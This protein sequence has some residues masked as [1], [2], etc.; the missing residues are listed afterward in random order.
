M[1][2]GYIAYWK[3]KGELYEKY[4]KTDRERILALPD[5]KY[6]SY[7]TKALK[8]KIDKRVGK[9][10][11]SPPRSNSKGAYNLSVNRSYPSSF[12]VEPRHYTANDSFFEKKHIDLFSNKVY[13]F[14][15]VDFSTPFD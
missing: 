5:N 4:K 6:R 11:Y 3:K 12:A 10:P 14:K 8:Y 2:Q 15:K 1:Y 9:I 7:K 13:F